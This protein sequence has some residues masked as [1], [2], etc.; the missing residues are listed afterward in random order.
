MLSRPYSSCVYGQEEQVGRLIGDLKQKIVEQSSSSFSSSTSDSSVLS[1]KPST[2]STTVDVECESSL[3]KSSY[4]SDPSHS[5]LTCI[6]A[7]VHSTK[8]DK[9][10][11]SIPYA[12]DKDCRC[13]K[14]CL[15]QLKKC[16][17][18]FYKVN[19]SPKILNPTLTLY[20]RVRLQLGC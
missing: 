8:R 15:K 11:S 14:N 2:A 1:C 6:P 4:F 20:S 18:T 9:N 10:E 5:V 12:V 3:S 7:T 19:Y 13:G 16:K 17:T